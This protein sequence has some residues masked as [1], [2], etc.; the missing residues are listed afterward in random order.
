MAA[1]VSALRTRAPQHPALARYEAIARILTGRNDATAD[2]GIAWVRT[3]CAELDIPSL[4]T[5]GIT[6]SD[7]PAVA[8][9][10]ARAS[11]MQANPLPLT[12]NEI[13]AVLATAL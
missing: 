8:E 11:S 6:E 5:W 9:K 2:D 3:L 4:R 1:N 10:A 13:L 7:L 12:S